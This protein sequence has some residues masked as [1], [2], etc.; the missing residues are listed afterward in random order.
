M[1]KQLRKRSEIER[2]VA[3]GQADKELPRQAIRETIT[4]CIISN[5]RVAEMLT[6]ASQNA[7]Q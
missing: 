6:S 2:M 3:D 5:E 7:T 4:G 1:A